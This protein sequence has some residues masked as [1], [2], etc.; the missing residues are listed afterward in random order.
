MTKACHTNRLSLEF[1]NAAVDKYNK[2]Q[3][4]LGTFQ[5]GSK[6]CEIIFSKAK[7]AV[8]QEW[9]NEGRDLKDLNVGAMEF[10][11]NV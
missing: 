1:H 10:T 9:I 5:H 7:L 3:A 11:F 2:M 6:N 4:N 8:V